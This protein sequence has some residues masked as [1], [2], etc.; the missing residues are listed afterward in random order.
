MILCKIF[1]LKMLIGQ[2]RCLP[3]FD[4]EK[5][6]VDSHRDFHIGQSENRF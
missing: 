1:K 6:V 4:P 2:Q 3:L 5:F